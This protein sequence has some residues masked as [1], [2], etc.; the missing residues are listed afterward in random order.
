MSGFVQTLVAAKVVCPVQGT[1]TICADVLAPR[2]IRRKVNIWMWQDGL[3]EI[4]LAP[5]RPHRVR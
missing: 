1:K 3:M 5:Q 2:H 4:L